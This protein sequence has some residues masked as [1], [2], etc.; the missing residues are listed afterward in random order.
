MN[1]NYE[2]VLILLGDLWGPFF[3]SI[4]LAM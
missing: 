2:N 4:L 1:I 3:F